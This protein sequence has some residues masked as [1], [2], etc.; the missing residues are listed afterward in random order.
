MSENVKRLYRSSKERMLGGVCG[1]LGEYFGID[2]TLVRLIYIV[3]TFLLP[4]FILIYLVL[5]LV[6]PQAP[7]PVGTASEQVIDTSAKE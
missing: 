2:P 3:L 1:G 7:E 5:W 6:I 4:F